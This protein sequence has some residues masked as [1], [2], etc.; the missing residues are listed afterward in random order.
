MLASGNYGTATVNNHTT[1][2]I[3]LWEMSRDRRGVIEDNRFLIVLAATSGPKRGQLVSLVLPVGD[4]AYRHTV[5]HATIVASHESDELGR[6]V[7]ECWGGLVT[8]YE[9][10]NPASIPTLSTDPS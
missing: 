2:D 10:T 3:V 6:W 7:I 5:T 4:T 9:P 8:M 1:Y